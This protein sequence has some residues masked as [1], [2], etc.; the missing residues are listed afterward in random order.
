[1]LPLPQQ[2]GVVEGLAMFVKQHPTLLPLSDQ[3]VLALISEL[4]KML[5]VGDGEMTDVA[6]KDHTIS[7]HGYVAS[8]LEIEQSTFHIYS[9]AMF[10]RRDSVA[11]IGKKKIVIPEEHPAGVQLRVS[12]IILLHST[13]LSHTEDFFD[14]EWVGKCRCTHLID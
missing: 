13:I 12:S 7:K 14:A 5:S 9:T 3:H 4:L 1:L 11:N 2:V 6:L 10:F 8:E